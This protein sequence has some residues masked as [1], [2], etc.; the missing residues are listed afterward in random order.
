MVTPS[1]K[2]TYWDLLLTYTNLVNRLQEL[3]ICAIFDDLCEYT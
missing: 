2:W 1:E 3:I